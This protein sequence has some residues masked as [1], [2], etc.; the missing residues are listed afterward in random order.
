MAACVADMPRYGPI[1]RHSNAKVDDTLPTGGTV[2]FIP[3]WRQPGLSPDAR[4]AAK[5]RGRWDF[6]SRR[7]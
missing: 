2:D 4:R 1:S 3:R 6:L 5:L 7:L